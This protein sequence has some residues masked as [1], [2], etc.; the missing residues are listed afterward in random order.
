MM[1]SSISSYIWPG[2]THVGF[3]AVDLAGQEAVAR[4]AKRV[5][6]IA[7]PGVVAVGLTEPVVASLAAAKV[8]HVIYDRV[9]PNPDAESVDAAGE[10]FRQSDADLIIGL[11]GGSGLDTA[12]AVRL[13][14]GG[15]PEGRI[16]E[17]ALMLGDQAQPTLQSHRMPPMIAIPTTAGTGSEVT[18]WAVIT[19]HAHR[20]KF[21]IGGPAL[22]PTVALVDPALTLTLPP[23]LTAATGIDALT[24]CIE[25]YVSTNNHNPALDSLI[26]YGVE[27]IGRSLR[28]AVVQG[29]NETARADMALAAVLGGIA[30]SSNWLGACHA[31]AHQLSSLADVQHGVANGLMLPHQMEYSLA[32]ALDRYA[33]LAEA[34]DQPRPVEGTP[35][36]RAERAVEAVRELIADIGLPTRL[37]DTGV[38]EALIPAL[39]KNAMVDLNWMTNPRAIDE[40]AM[41]ALYRQAY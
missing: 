31:L 18:P 21:G 39:A 10:A 36:R 4:E 17:Y 3:G 23:K 34:L 37:R 26:L 19:D 35:R 5:F 20:L 28:V 14:A 40:A 13:L 7:D 12:K 15:S 33:R 8:A 11:G 32:G 16:A 30:I 25:A 6:I 27:L 24:H 1:K 2:Q 41:K 9:V 38:T 29:A 22:I